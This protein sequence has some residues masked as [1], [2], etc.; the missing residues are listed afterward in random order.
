MISSGRL[1]PKN[2]I[3]KHMGNRPRALLGHLPNDTP[4][5]STWQHVKAERQTAGADPADVSVALHM[6]LSMDRQ[7]EHGPEKGK[8]VFRKDH[9]PSR[10]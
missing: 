5:K 10:S 1:F 4:A 9:A 7:L 3:G 8:P 2:T 6:V